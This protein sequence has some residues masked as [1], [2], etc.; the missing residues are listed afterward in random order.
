MERR[1]AIS[2]GAVEASGVLYQ[3][4]TATKVWQALPITASVNTWGDE[5]YFTIPVEAELENAK[6]TVEM[7]DIAY[8]PEGRAMCIFFGPTP[9]SKGDEIRPA[10]PVNVIGKVDG[11]ATVFKGVGAGQTITI[12]GQ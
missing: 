2:A 8:W 6:E 11:D 9:I 3:T 10:G 5:V 12:A 7:G 1:I 4:A